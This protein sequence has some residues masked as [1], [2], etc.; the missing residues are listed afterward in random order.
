M[1]LHNRILLFTATL[2]CGSLAWSQF[3]NVFEIQA[4][5]MNEV[6]SQAYELNTEK[7]PQSAL[8][9]IAKAQGNLEK[10]KGVIPNFN[11]TTV[12]EVSFDDA[13]ST[14]LKTKISSSEVFNFQRLPESSRSQVLQALEQKYS[15]AFFDMALQMRRFQLHHAYA[16]RSIIK[17]AS[18]T[19]ASALSAEI[20]AM[21]EIV[22]ILSF[23][24]LLKN[25]ASGIMYSFDFADILSSSI[26]KTAISTEYASI[27]SRLVE[28]YVEIAADSKDA[29]LVALKN[30]K[31]PNALTAKLFSEIQFKKAESYK[32]A[33]A[34]EGNKLYVQ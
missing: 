4:T 34:S 25:S 31:K 28:L 18:L 7:K 6:N 17:N 15:S 19:G 20:K 27:N 14:K 16:L 9:I 22:K 21:N 1:K 26:S 12:F 32:L 11:P 33:M 10:Q 3:A 29:D 23:P 8:E 24:F 13:I 5:A 30:S 2:S